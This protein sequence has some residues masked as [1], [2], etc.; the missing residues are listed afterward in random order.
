MDRKND[1]S[2]KNNE[3]AKKTAYNNQW[4]STSLNNYPDDRERRDGPGGN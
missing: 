4:T 3:E 2:K 1:S